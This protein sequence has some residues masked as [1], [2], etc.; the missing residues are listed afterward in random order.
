[1]DEDVGALLQI[2]HLAKKLL[3]MGMRDV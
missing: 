2:K 1:V 3:P